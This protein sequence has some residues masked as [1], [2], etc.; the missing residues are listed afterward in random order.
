M[1][2]KLQNSVQSIEVAVLFRIQRASSSSIRRA[3]SF[4]LSSLVSEACQLRTTSS[5]VSTST[6]KN[7]SVISIS[8]HENAWR[9]MAKS[10]AWIWSCPDILEA[11]GRAHCLSAFKYNERFDPQTANIDLRIDWMDFTLDV[12]TYVPALWR[13]TGTS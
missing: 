1:K 3:T 12:L 13:Q 7:P 4:H 10:S 5:T 8:G 9:K 11:E 2:Q 6:T